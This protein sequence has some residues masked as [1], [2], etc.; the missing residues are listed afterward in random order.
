MP[1]PYNHRFIQSNDNLL[2]GV[3][4]ARAKARLERKL[5]LKQAQLERRKQR[6]EYLYR[7]SEAQLNMVNATL[8]KM[9]N[10]D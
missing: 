7:Q 10:F 6:L 4:D 1:R 3:A 5:T 2:I 9:N 8:Q